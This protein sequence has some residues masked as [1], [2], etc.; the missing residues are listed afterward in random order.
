ML[1]CQWPCQ[2]EREKGSLGNIQLSHI[3]LVFLC[4][5]VKKR[6]SV[7]PQHFSL[8]ALSLC[9]AKRKKMLL[10]SASLSSLFLRK[11]TDHKRLKRSSQ[12]IKES[13][14]NFQPFNFLLLKKVLFIQKVI[15]VGKILKHEW[16]Y[17]FLDVGYLKM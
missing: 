13:S 3:S 17:H 15:L 5:H 2:R 9:C 14:F 12:K 6:K 7:A 11:Q 8:S 4:M 1:F 16:Q 10:S